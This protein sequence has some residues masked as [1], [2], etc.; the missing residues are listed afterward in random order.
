MLKIFYQNA[1]VA[2]ATFVIE[3]LLQKNMKRL[4]NSVRR[5]H[6]DCKCYK[7]NTFEFSVRFVTGWAAVTPC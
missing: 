7:V 3:M 1:L 6:E 5:G 4:E 2:G